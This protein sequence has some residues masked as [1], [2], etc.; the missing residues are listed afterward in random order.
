[1]NAIFW[2]NRFQFIALYQMRSDNFAAIYSCN[3][4]NENKVTLVL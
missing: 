4:D 3:N 2:L 1:M